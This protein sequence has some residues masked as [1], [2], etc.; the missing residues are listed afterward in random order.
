MGQYDSR[1]MGKGFSP[2]MGE[3]RSITR[4]RSDPFARSPEEV[5]QVVHDLKTHQIELEMQND[6]LRRIQRELQLAHDKYVDLYDFAPMGYCTIGKNG[7]IIEANLSAAELLGLERKALLGK[8]FNGFI[9]PSS[10]DAFHFHEN[11]VISSKSLQTCEVEL[12]KHDG[13]FISCRIESRR[14]RDLEGWTGVWRTHIVDITEQKRSRAELESAEIQWRQTFDSISDMVAVLDDAQRIVRANKAVADFVGVV[15]EELVG[16]PCREVFHMEKHPSECPFTELCN[17][18]KPLL[19]ELDN[20]D[21]GVPL[22][23]SLSPIFKIQKHDDGER[24]PGEVD[25]AVL[26][27]KDVSELKRMEKESLKAKN[28]ESL[29]LLAGG[30]AH[31]FNNLLMSVMGNVDLAAMFLDPKH[32][33]AECLNRAARGCMQASE[34]T[35]QLLTFAKG[36][37]PL[38][39]GARINEVVTDSCE[40]VAR[41]SNMECDC[42]FFDDLWSVD[43]DRSQISRV[44]QNLTQNAMEAMPEG[45]TVRIRG[46][47]ITITDADAHLPLRGK[48]YVKISVS[49]NGPGIPEG[50]KSKIFDPYF[51]TKEQG[52]KKGMGLGLSVCHSI[53]AKHD[54][55]ITIESKP[56]EGA[57]FNVFIPAAENIPVKEVVL[58]ETGKLPTQCGGRILV[59]EDE[60]SVAQIVGKLLDALGCEATYAKNSQE[61]VARYGEAMASGTP[62]AAVLLDLTVKGGKGGKETLEKILKIDKNAKA[63]VSS[64][65]PNDPV[66]VNYEEYGFI[67]AMAKP[68][69]LTALSEIL[70]KISDKI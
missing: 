11:R 65:Y 27:A 3:R 42:E 21:I 69:T 57:T 54:G 43:I 49:D 7:E 36:G 47:N 35:K 29:G 66:M 52:A 10:Q 40:F 1:N 2:L 17:K 61:A 14:V 63:I 4:R 41:G 31:D 53:V 16:K 25:G 45:G 51:S 33:A 59:M 15:Q 12:K 19:F 22:L 13:T 24:D 20:P 26:I 37:A 48:H 62:F 34:L 39:K 70:L 28:L 60:E 68:Y 58:S 56:E 23:I 64:G 8:R 9:A 32:K 18:K 30:I 6:E 67:G 38:R 46:E 44:I 55:L 50:L 5:S